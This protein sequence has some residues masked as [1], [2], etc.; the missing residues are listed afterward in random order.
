VRHVRPIVLLYLLLGVVP[1]LVGG[2]GLASYLLLHAGYSFLVWGLLP[3]G[4]L[5]L[6][7]SGLGAVLGTAASGNL[8]G[9]RRKEEKPH[10][11]APRGRPRR[12]DDV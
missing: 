12:V 6:L 7:A 8:P 4:A 9:P 3:F 10:G 5:L 11:E 1:L 2:A